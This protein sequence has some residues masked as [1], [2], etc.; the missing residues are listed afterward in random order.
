M[1]RNEEALDVTLKIGREVTR[2]RSL[3]MRLRRFARLDPPEV[4]AIE[5]KTVID[6]ARQLFEHQ[7]EMGG[8]HYHEDIPPVTVLVDSERFSLAIANIVSNACD[9]MADIGQKQVTLNAQIDDDKL[10]LSIR[11]TGPGLPPDI[12]KR[13]FEPFFTTKQDGLGLGLAISVES[14]ASMNGLIEVANHPDGGA[15]FTLI[16]P[17]EQ[18]S[19]Q[20]S[21]ALPIEIS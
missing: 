13:V 19:R 17:I 18:T 14:I 8:V 11:D 16:V 5:L 9:A 21:E 7:L 1:Q 3:I 2:L 10:R 4:E 15:E 20:T 6:D 12:L